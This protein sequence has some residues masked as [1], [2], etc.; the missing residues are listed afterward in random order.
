M[1]HATYEKNIQS[2][3]SWKYSTGKAKVFYWTLYSRAGKE[4][5]KNDRELVASLRQEDGGKKRLTVE[6]KCRERKRERGSKREWKIETQ[7]DRQAQ[8]Q[9]E[10]MRSSK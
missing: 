10:K 2:K 9:K 6:A 7:R 8:K 4:T 3:T 1:H 5:E